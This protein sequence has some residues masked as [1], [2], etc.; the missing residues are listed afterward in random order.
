ML[1]NPAIRS[2]PQPKQQQCYMF[3][4]IIDMHDL[5]MKDTAQYE[6]T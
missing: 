1:K 5:N 4:H 3:Y 6:K 2:Q